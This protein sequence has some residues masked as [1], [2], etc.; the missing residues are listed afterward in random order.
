M[1]GEV[2]AADFGSRTSSGQLG[3]ISGA[4]HVSISLIGRVHKDG[5]V[6]YAR[7]VFYIF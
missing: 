7:S 5:L 6:A 2:G 1:A 3:V 4:I